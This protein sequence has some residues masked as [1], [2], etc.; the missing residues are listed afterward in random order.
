VGFNVG[1]TVNF[2][3]RLRKVV[4]RNVNLKSNR[5][6]GREVKSTPRIGTG[7]YFGQK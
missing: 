1:P 6:S 7:T 2:A 3:N 4:K 5:P